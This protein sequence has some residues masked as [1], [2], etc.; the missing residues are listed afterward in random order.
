MHD[1]STRWVVLLI[2]LIMLP[3]SL[4]NY[5]KLLVI[6]DSADR[7]MVE[8]WCSHHKGNLFK[9]IDAVVTNDTSIDILK[10]ILDPYRSRF[11]S[12]EMRVCELWQRKVYV[13]MISNKF[14]VRS[15]PPWHMPIRTMS[16]MEKELIDSN[17][18][19]IELFNFALAPGLKILE[20]AMGGAPHGVLVNSAFW[21]LS[22]PD[23][24][25]T[26]TPQNKAEWIQ[27]WSTNVTSFLGIIKQQF[28]STKWFGWHTANRFHP[29]GST[30]TSDFALKLL[31]E[32]NAASKFIATETGYEW[33]DFASYK[34]VL[35][36]ALHPSP[37]S[38]IKLCDD[39]LSRV[40][41]T[42]STIV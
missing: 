3:M 29:F 16:G 36:D 25:H 27:S 19:L 28:P 1:V 31:Y 4:S 18:S 9:E 8:E 2:L 6:G 21:D 17:F 32:M 20:T 24:M 38:L 14:G 33:I 41:E 34:I 5:I 26:R 22:H 23:P 30:W 15:H 35:K 42:L 10:P 7:I 13:S 37:P 11:R 39:T 40:N 12:W